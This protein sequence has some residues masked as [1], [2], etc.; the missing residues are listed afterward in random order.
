MSDEKRRGCEEC[1]W[2]G[3]VHMREPFEI[4]V[5]DTCAGG[6]VSDRD[7][8][9]WHRPVWACQLI[10]YNPRSTNAEVSVDTPLLLTMLMTA[11]R[12]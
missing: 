9:E 4:Q 3:W 7:A 2:K 12:W 10:L 1:G 6:E 5:C 11:A 8:I